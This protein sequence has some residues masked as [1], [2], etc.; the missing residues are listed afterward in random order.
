MADPLF[1]KSPDD[2]KG[3]ERD[4]FVM[5]D[6]GDETLYWSCQPAKPLDAY[7][8][9]SEVRLWCDTERDLIYVFEMVHLREFVK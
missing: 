2:F 9:L 4:S 1:Y 3:M 6:D 7:R 5:S 8:Q